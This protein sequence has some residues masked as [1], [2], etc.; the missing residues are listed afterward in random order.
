MKRMRPLTLTLTLRRVVAR[1]GVMLLA[2]AALASVGCMRGATEGDAPAPSVTGG[3]SSA[4]RMPVELNQV[5]ALAVDGGRVWLATSGGIVVLNPRSNSAI[6]LVGDDR[7]SNANATDIAIAPNGV[8]WTSHGLSARER[9]RREEGAAGPE[10]S[11]PPG[12]ETRAREGGI[13]AFG[14]EGA[15]T[16]F[17]AEDGLG[18]DEIDSI[19]AGRD[20]VIAAA[21][22]ALA[23]LRTGAPGSHF[24]TRLTESPRR[25]QVIDLAAGASA[26]R[27]VEFRPRAE[28]M[29]AVA[30]DGSA[31]LVGSTDAIYRI[32]GDELLRFAP[33][34]RVNGGIPSHVIALAPLPG[35][36]IASLGVP[37]APG[38]APLP[39]GLAEVRDF[40]RIARCHAP[41]FDVPAATT[42]DVAVDGQVI[43]LA[44][45][46]GIV[47]IKG[48]DPELL[49]RGVEIPAPAP[50]AIA[51]D[52]QGGVWVGTWG[53]GTW[54]LADGLIDTYMIGAAGDVKVQTTRS[55][56]GPE[57]MTR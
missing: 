48:D 41:A 14:K 33:A 16:A 12:G 37:G 3:S 51:G 20:L 26:R 18:T 40:G 42:L 35:G 36:F 52:G 5:A 53:G 13:R 50:T 4:A 54:H 10:V 25:L 32:D 27:V 38:D 21:G 57:A 55:G 7:V 47:R 24:E 31:L 45:Y 39:G 29:T 8:T 22:P 11:A 46:E 23:I 17:F 34:C 44:T 30:I 15:V 56:A 6:V 1:V 49:V 2:G 28:R 43:W 19:A 9:G